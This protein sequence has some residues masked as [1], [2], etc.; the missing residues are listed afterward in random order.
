MHDAKAFYTARHG[1]GYTVFEHNSHA[2][3]QELVV[4]VPVDSAG[5]LPFLV[6]AGGTVCYGLFMFFQ[7]VYYD[8]DKQ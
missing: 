6:V 3:E 2:I 8:S 5:G 4:V 7:G 1:Q